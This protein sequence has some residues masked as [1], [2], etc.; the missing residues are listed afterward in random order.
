[1]V[2]FKYTGSNFLFI[3][4]IKNVFLHTVCSGLVSL[5]LFVW[6]TPEK[7]KEQSEK[8]EK[9]ILRAALPLPIWRLDHITQTFYITPEGSGLSWSLL[10]FPLYLHWLFLNLMTVSLLFLV[11]HQ[12]LE[13]IHQIFLSFNQIRYKPTLHFPKS[14]QILDIIM[15]TILK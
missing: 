9:G 3:H 1:M 12:S 10:R 5:R 14:S 4:T 15:N 6:S 11:T 2:S 7:G 13:R 8:V